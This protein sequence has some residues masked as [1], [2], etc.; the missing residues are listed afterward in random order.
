M[1]T[2]IPK[3]IREIQ[4]MDIQV[5]ELIHLYEEMARQHTERQLGE[6]NWNIAAAI[7]ADRYREN[8]GRCFCIMER[9]RLFAGV[10]G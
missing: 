5:E 1:P 3:T 2:R 8:F 6:V 10:I 7:L 9:M 4:A